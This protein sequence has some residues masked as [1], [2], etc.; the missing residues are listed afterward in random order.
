MPPAVVKEHCRGLCILSLFKTSILQLTDGHY[1]LS[2]LGCVCV[3]MRM[4]LGET[5]IDP[6]RK[7]GTEQR[8]IHSSNTTPLP[9]IS[10]V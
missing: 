7:N 1:Y 6:V 10:N 8:A 4:P 9:Q 5:E 2:K 3:H